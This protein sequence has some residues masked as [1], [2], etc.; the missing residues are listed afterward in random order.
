VFRYGVA[1]FHLNGVHRWVGYDLCSL[2]IS[3]SC[4]MA[5][6][7]RANLDPPGSADSDE[8][9]IP[10]RNPPTNSTLIAMAFPLL[11]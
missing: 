11:A 6:T 1:T 3:P 8:A 2:P 4:D 7:K 5:Y 9:R 10:S